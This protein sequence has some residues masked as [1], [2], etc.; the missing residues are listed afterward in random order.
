M[1]VTVSVQFRDSRPACECLSAGGLVDTVPNARVLACCKWDWLL[2][3][4]E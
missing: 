2:I 4:I 3:G 1:G